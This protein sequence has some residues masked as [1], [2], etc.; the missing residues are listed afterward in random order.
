MKKSKKNSTKYD[1]DENDDVS[2]R[3][4]FS[5]DPLEDISSEQPTFYDYEKKE[6]K[7]L[8][9]NNQTY[10]PVQRKSLGFGVNLTPQNTFL[11]TKIKS[12]DY[13]PSN[14]SIFHPSNSIFSLPIVNPNR[15]IIRLENSRPIQMISPQAKTMVVKNNQ[16]KPNL[17]TKIVY[18]KPQN[19]VLISLP[20]TNNIDSN[21]SSVI[22]TQPHDNSFST[23]LYSS[24]NPNGNSNKTKVIHHYH[25]YENPFKFLQKNKITRTRAET[26]KQTNIPVF[27][28]AAQIQFMKRNN[29]QTDKNDFENYET[30][31]LTSRTSPRSSPNFDTNNYFLYHNRNN[32]KK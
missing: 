4:L 7:S 18:N 15:K 19:N 16:N 32:L 27:N 3:S 24:P 17:F 30:R 12:I 1:D 5:P 22:F 21:R 11:N 2:I 28:S 6:H 14:K 10:N 20:R 23:L 29:G 31:F 8:H 25:F 26:V 9:Q 13:F